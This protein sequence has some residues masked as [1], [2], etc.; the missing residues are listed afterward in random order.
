MKNVFFAMLC[1]AFTI[2]AC[3][4]DDN[5][6]KSSPDTTK[7]EVN[8]ATINENIVGEWVVDYA[9]DSP[10]GY[11]WEIIKFLE[12][13]TMYFSNYSEK[14]DIHH[15]Y[16]SGTYS[17]KDNV[18]ATNC[19]LGFSDLYL[20][21]NSD[22]KVQSINE[23]EMV[24]ELVVHDDTAKHVAT[25]HYKKVVGSLVID[26]EETTPNYQK[27]C[28]SG[29]ILSYK[30]HNG[31]IVNVNEKTGALKGVWAGST[32]IDIVT[33][34]GTAVLHVSVNTMFDYDYERYIGLPMDSIPKAF[35][36]ARMDPN[37]EG[38]HI[39][40]DGYYPTIISSEG[41]WIYIYNADY[42]PALQA[43]SGNW[44][45]MEVVFNK[46]TKKT[47]AISLVAKDEAWFTQ[48]QLGDYLEERY[49][50]YDKEPEEYWDGEGA[51]IKVENTW[52]A[53]INTPTLDKSTVGVSWNGK[54]V[55]SFVGV[56]QRLYYQI[57]QEEYTPDY[58]KIF[59]NEQPLGYASLNKYV[60]TVD[61]TTGKI[62]G[63]DSGSARIKITT[64][65]DVYSL[66][67]RVNAF[68]A[69]DYESLLGKTQKDVVDFYGVVPYYA[70][71]EDWIFRYNSLLF[72]QDRRNV[73]NWESMLV[74]MSNR[75]TGIVTELMLTAKEDVWFTAEEFDQYLAANYHA[76]TEDT[77]ET[78]KAYINNSDYG[79]ASTE[80]LWDTNNKVLTFKMVTHDDV[81]PTFNYG[82]YIGKTHDEAIEMMNSE[83]GVSPSTDDSAN[84]QFRMAG[85]VFHVMFKY[86]SSGA[87]NFIQVR[88]ETTVDPKDVNE[89]LSKAYTLL[90]DSTG[91]YY[92][93]SYDGRVRVTYMPS[94]NRMSNVIQFKVR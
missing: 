22:I 69:E 20:T 78:T 58:K 86:D 5:E 9:E 54:E 83:Y 64:D 30:S 14:K 7:Q 34:K 82:R 43:K 16:V 29:K 42:N 66:R 44:D 80:L 33:D 10:E 48:Y 53:Y 45:Y 25:N 3:C 46:D 67:V 37:V 94:T 1:C 76:Y 77:N 47:E 50:L 6:V 68:L 19:Q 88:L 55:I 90:D 35:K 87:I 89:E 8:A 15:N 59:G 74:K 72:P 40:K 13:G 32:Y 73:G 18:I 51:L 17:V 11:S 60:A 4:K 61:K 85:D 39:Y 92:Y 24:A 84:L 62:T 65:Q 71:G 21:Q 75:W 36:F 12:S 52:K 31:Y 63:H 56:Q 28:A 93:D 91:N 2:L 70:D 27:Y 38:S 23:Y 79:K 41:T 81:L 26:H 57:G 49:Y